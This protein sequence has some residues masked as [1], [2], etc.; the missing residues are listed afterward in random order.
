MNNTPIQSDPT[1]EQ[2]CIQSLEKL[3]SSPV[4]LAYLNELKSKKIGLVLSGGGGKGAYEAGALLALFDCGIR[5]FCAIAG[6]SVGALNAALAYELSRTGDRNVVT[7]TW[8]DMSTCKVLKLYPIQFL[9]GLGF[10]ILVVLAKI[11]VYLDILLITLLEKI[12]DK[13]GQAWRAAHYRSTNYAGVVL[14]L[15][16]FPSSV[17]ILY[18][19]KHSTPDFQEVLRFSA[20]ILGPMCF[21]YLLRD[22][23][24]SHLSLFSN[25]PLQKVIENTIDIDA[26]RSSSVPIY[27]TITSVVK[28]WDP[29][30]PGPLETVADS[31]MRISSAA[32]YFKLTDTETTKDA[33]RLLLQSAAL[34]HF[35]P[36]KKVKG[37]YSVDGGLEDNTPIYPVFIHS[38]EI[39]IVVYLDH[40]LALEDDLYLKEAARLWW[41]MESYLQSTL[42][43]QMA[44]Q[45]RL[46]FIRKHGEIGK[47]GNYINP[48][49]ILFGRDQYIAIVPSQSLGGIRKGTLNFTGKKATRLMKAGY[50][51]TLMALTN[52][53]DKY[54]PE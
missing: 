17:L 24:G 13:F 33:I 5:Q 38:P 10:R 39:F 15:T 2:D 7:K 9:L 27:C 25:I 21:I 4:V 41:N 32:S 46:K 29:F 3:L 53:A 8:S 11:P 20:I 23:I 43:R 42:S 18:L 52:K 36:R 16:I 31:A 28:W 49:I 48:P 40:K 22:I 1:G 37:V 12:S 45:E 35:F 34:P 51:D 54:D 47:K 30:E 50:L 14:I 44:N 6:T 26:V 19:W